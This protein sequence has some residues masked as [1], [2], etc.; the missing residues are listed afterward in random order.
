MAL[1]VSNETPP[2]LD[3]AIARVAAASSLVLGVLV[4]ALGIV[5]GAAREWITGSAVNV[6]AAWADGF[7]LVIALGTAAAVLGAFLLQGRLWAHAVLLAGFSVGVGVQVVL[8]LRTLLPAGA[9][10]QPGAG[11]G[12]LA[13]VLMLA[14][15]AGLA[16]IL[17][18][19]SAPGSRM[20]FASNVVVA[21]ALAA[22]C[23]VAVNVVL[24]QKGNYW[25]RDVE[26]LRQYGL[27]ERSLKVVKAVNE[28]MRLT[29]LYSASD[30]NAVYQRR[31]A[32]VWEL[33]GEIREANPR[34]EVARAETDAERARVLA[35]VVEQANQ[36]AP[37]H[38][39]LLND[40]VAKVGRGQTLLDQLRDQQQQWK[41]LSGKSYLDLWGVA[42]Q[43]DTSYATLAKQVEKAR[44]DVQTAMAGLPDHAKLAAGLKELAVSE[45]E[46]LAR[47]NQNLELIAK[48]PPAVSAN[49]K[50]VLEKLDE[51][52]KAVLQA[53]RILGDGND[54][55]PP[56]DPN[57]VLRRFAAAVEGAAEKLSTAV[58]GLE[59]V[60]GPQNAGLVRN[61]GAWLM[62]VRLGG[63][64]ARNLLTYAYTDQIQDLAESGNFADSA[65]RAGTL[66]YQSKIV[67]ELRPGFAQTVASLAA[68]N[69]FSRGA[70]DRLAQVD[71]PTR[72][73][74]DQVA[75]GTFIQPTADLLAA[76]IKEA[77]ALPALPATTLADDINEQNT[78]LVE[79]ADKTEV[80]RFDQVWL[81]RA[82]AMGA[83]E[84]EGA[85]PRPDFNG[86][87][88]IGARIL[89]MTQKVC[90][91]AILTYV[92]APASPYGGDR[93]GLPEGYDEMRA[94]LEQANVRVVTWDL[95]TNESPVNAEEANLPSGTPRVLI[96]LPPPPAPY[97]GM[98]RPDDP[99]AFGPRH[100]Q[101][102]RKAI[103]AGAGAVFLAQFTMPRSLYDP[104]PSYGW[105]EYL[106]RDWGL[107][108]QVGH[109]I[110]P[111][112]REKTGKR[113]QLD[114]DR[115]F[116]LPLSTFTDHPIGTPLQGQRVFW[117]LACPVA[118]GPQRPPG[119]SVS[120][121]LSVPD[122]WD[123]TWA[124]NNFRRLLEQ[125]RAGDGS[126]IEPKCVRDAN[127]RL[128]P[129]GDLT[130]PLD[131]AVA[132]TRE[133]EPNQH[134][135]TGRIVVMGMAASLTDPYVT[136]QVQVQKEN[137]FVFEDPPRGN[138][139]VVVN[140]VYWLCGRGDLIASGPIAVRPI[141][142]IPK[143]TQQVLW[144]LCVVG[145]PAV[146][147]GIGGLVLLMR[148]R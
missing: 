109:W 64:L 94:R 79:A 128:D 36:R 129:S 63:R 38:I 19:A 70:V 107:E 116:Y 61:S 100:V 17:W 108:A 14:V 25:R 30:P 97:P 105:N 26:W 27:S 44:A 81:A 16:A 131:L 46:D 12:I 135:A 132:A 84:P 134:I 115:L 77:N 118:V 6:P 112:K 122:T 147:L 95:S 20:R 15:T 29:S 33:L 3:M 18:K 141:R 86:D 126:Y 99:S 59:E 142:N 49:R 13:G 31:A 55:A 56:A 103:D 111:A 40:F 21:A 88:A 48:V 121:I 60:A 72:R 101:R 90:G 144:T 9:M 104:P 78:I 139:D 24:Q 73:V 124:T 102:L 5:L 145:L 62:Y 22:S 143:G 93:G 91:V 137:A 35:R 74:L 136:S 127:G 85:D 82:G 119:V 32:R 45:K 89:A 69:E 8:L 68:L 113:F 53:G 75:E 51:A 146:V 39:K 125:L 92:P 41:Q 67:V 140:S 10:S 1:N 4:A 98:V 28:P 80:I 42:A 138:M 34:I 117:C 83:S 43:L 50:A 2:M 123:D 148:R 120:P 114:S 76:I 87:S 96:V 106:S 66:E 37:A 7:V 47:F 54:T 11:Q 110:I 130:A 65:L 58:G 71:P 57:G 23:A 52:Q 133:G